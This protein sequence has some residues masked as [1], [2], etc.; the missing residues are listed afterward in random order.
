MVQFY[1]KLIEDHNVCNDIQKSNVSKYQHTVLNELHKYQNFKLSDDELYNLQTKIENL[2][3]QFDD[4]KNIY[5]ITPDLIKLMICKDK[6]SA[7]DFLKSCRCLYPDDLECI[8]CFDQYSL[9]AIM[10]YVMGTLFNCINEN[11]AVRVSTLIDH[12][13]MTVKIQ[14][15]LFKNRNIA[16]IPPQPN[17]IS[18][19]TDNK[20][21]TTDNKKAIDKKEQATDKQAKKKVYVIGSLLVEFLVARKLIVLSN[22]L[23]FTEVYTAKKNKGK[24]YYPKTLYATCN[25]DINLLPIK[26]NLPMVCKPEDWVSAKD[27]PKSLSDLRGGYLNKPIGDFYHRYNLLTS[28]DMIH[29]HIVFET[30]SKMLCS[31]INAL[32]QQSFEINKD[33]LNFINKN[34]G[35]IRFTYA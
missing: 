6:P 22:E 13:D 30:D 1:D 23:S 16:L 26:L 29:F 4:F 9:E 33:V 21:Q 17:N 11:P 35:E 34:Y 27:T 15:K 19:N 7:K 3:T 14:A 28:R 25:F 24:Y 12:L 2:T 5:Q 31:F 20:E 10:L 8:D 32:Q 18:T